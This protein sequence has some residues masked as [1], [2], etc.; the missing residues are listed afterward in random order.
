MIQLHLTDDV[1]QGGGGK[2]LDGCD[3]LV[4]TV[5]VELGIH[6]LEEHHG[7]DLHGNVIAG[8]HRLGRKVRDL[9]LQADLFGDPLNERDLDMQAGRPGVGVAAQTLHN[10]HHGLRHDDDVGDDD[11]QDDKDEREDHEQHDR[12]RDAPFFSG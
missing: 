3:G 7:V 1:A 11:E 2:A 4:D 9:L 6:D 8:D 12:H 5:G 10:V